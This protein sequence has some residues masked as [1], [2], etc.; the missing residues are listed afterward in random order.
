MR[1]IRLYGLYFGHIKMKSVDVKT[2]ERGWMGSYNE[3]KL[4]LK[5]FT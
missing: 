5:I 2:D 4:M 3:I 1:H